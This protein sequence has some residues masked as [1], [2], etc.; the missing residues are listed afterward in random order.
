[1]KKLL[2]TCV[3]ILLYQVI[4]LLGA[5]ELLLH[6][7]TLVIIAT[8]AV[9]WLSQPAIRTEEASTNK[10]TDRNTVWIILAMAGVSTI[11]PE[12]EWAYFTQDINGSLLWNTIGLALVGSGILFRVWAIRTLGRF[13]TSTVQ[14]SREHQLVTAGPYALVRHPSYLGA[15][16]TILG[17]TVLLQAWTGLVVGAAAMFYAYYQRIKVEEAALL[18]QFGERYAEYVMNRKKM[19]P[20]IW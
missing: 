7:K 3:A 20:A 19:L 13:F 16:V 4:P 14:T 15:F 11:V 2:F 18:A 10:T 6:W 5:P 17:I 12:L 8:A 9:L 1:M